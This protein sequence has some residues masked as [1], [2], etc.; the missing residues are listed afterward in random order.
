[1]SY[2]FDTRCV[3]GT[4]EHAYKDGVCS[5]SFPIYQSATFAHTKIEHGQFN[6]TRQDNPTRLHLEETIA[7]LEEGHDAV[8]FASGM[9]A[10]AAVFELFR[11]GDHIICSEDLYGGT[12]RLFR[13]VGSK[14][15]LD[16]AFTDTTDAEKVRAAL[17]P[18]TRAIYIETPS[19]PM[20]NVTDIRACAAIAHKAGALLIVDNTFLSPAFQQ[21]LALGADLVVHSGSKYLSG[22][23]DTI[24]GFVVTSTTALSDAIRLIG[25]TTG[26]MLA[27]FDC[28]LVM[29]GVKTL[30]L[31]MERAQQ[32][33]LTLAR[34]LKENPHVTQ[35]LYVGLP[36]HPGYAINRSQAHGTGGMLSFRVDSAETAQRVLTG[37]K[38]ITFAESLGSTESLI[39]YPLTQTHSDVPEDM[40]RRLGITDT[41]LRLSVGIEDVNDLL[42]DLTQA[43]GD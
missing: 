4:P 39:T 17:R 7:A 15:G 13:N 24:C 19:N 42:A 21:P 22:H 28:W 5:V 41:L 36:E 26:G 31:R 38:V 11:P 30:S 43:L 37:V 27:P 20:M 6:Y 34:A 33:A 2:R 12:T 25:K 18:G 1:M 32:S 10:I 29:R 40:R 16:I 14:N 9:A 35:V 3:H 8:A 23:N